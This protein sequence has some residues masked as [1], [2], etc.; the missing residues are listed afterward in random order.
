MRLQ[1]L[2]LCSDMSNDSSG[3]RKHSVE[4]FDT[5]GRGFDVELELRVRKEEG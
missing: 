5:G 4:G 3:E 2:H 1:C